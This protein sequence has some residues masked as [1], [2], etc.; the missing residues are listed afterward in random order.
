MK[1]ITISMLLLAAAISA[2]WGEKISLA[3]FYPAWDQLRWE[4]GSQE[5]SDVF[6]QVVT[7][8]ESANRRC[9]GYYFYLDTRTVG[10]TNYYYLEDGDWLY[11][12]RMDV[13]SNLFPI[14]LSFQ[15]QSRMPAFPLRINDVNSLTWHWEGRYTSV[16]LRKSIKADFRMERNVDVDC[17]RGRSKGLKLYA[18][19]TDGNSVDHLESWHVQDLGLV[20]F[21][22]PNHVKRLTVFRP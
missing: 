12:G 4:Y 5:G 1:K 18:T 16:L 13:K 3:A 2:A 17:I 10:H 20:Y 6:T 7:F 19:Y 14:A 9:S 15:V 21:S 11:L 8:I 22:G